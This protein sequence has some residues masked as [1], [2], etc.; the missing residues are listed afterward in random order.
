HADVTATATVEVA[1][2]GVPVATD[3]R[4]TTP[5]S[6]ALTF[7]LD[8]TDPEGDDLT[9][10]VDPAVRGIGCDIVC[11]AGGECTYTPPAATGGDAIVSFT[12]A[13]E[14]GT[15]HGTVT[16]TVDDPIIDSLEVSAPA[17][18]DQGDTIALTVEA[19]DAWD[20]SLGDVTGDAT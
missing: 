3:S 15:S 4:E 19:F 14:F 8:A 17:T 10:T 18:A 5:A 2:D 12:V 9:F 6:T 13:D 7:A 11:D 1:A 16:I 20:V